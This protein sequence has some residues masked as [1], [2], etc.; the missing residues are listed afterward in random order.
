MSKQTRF[1]GYTYAVV[2]DG[3]TQ[4]VLTTREQ[5]REVKRTLKAQNKFDSVVL[6]QAVAFQVIR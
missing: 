3:Y 1:S 6:I 2:A 4:A 5:A